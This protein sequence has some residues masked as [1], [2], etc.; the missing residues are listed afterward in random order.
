MKIL[1]VLD[2][3]YPN[4]DGPIEVVVNL[5]KKFIERGNEAELLVPKYP[6]KIE[7]EGLKI[8]RCVSVPAQGY[9]GA[10]PALDGKIKKLIKKGNFDLINLHSPFTLGRCAQKL[11][12]KYGI[13]VVFTMHTKFR[14]EFETR[15]KS[16]FLCK[17]MLNY[18]MKCID[19]CDAVTT[20]SRGTVD[21]LRDYGYK[22]AADVKVIYNGTAMPQR[23]YNAEAVQKL[24]AAL[25]LE[26]KLA[27]TFVGR[28][29]EVK[30]VQFSLAV[31]NKVKKSGLDGF[32]FVIVGDGAYGKTLEKLTADYNLQDNVTFV[33]KISDK[34]LLANYYA[35][36]D[37]LLFPSVFDNASIVI[38]EA[39][40]NGLPVATLQGC[41]SA[42][43][44]TDGVSGFVWK[45]DEDVWAEKI[46]EIIKNPALAAAA[47]EGAVKSV[48]SGWD[49]IAEQYLAY[50]AKA[51]QSLEKS[52]KNG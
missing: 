22:K 20:V 16:K 38:L 25:G 6:Q 40:A 9:R 10:L 48:Y 5:A 12:K 18:V 39:A 23:G 19:A 13:P 7:V 32:K 4:V 44:L 52:G 26:G 27:L 3:F 30:N 31:L 45:N 33:G 15:L 47:G 46:S 11:G 29:A 41:C 34:K 8:H 21:T 2:S 50:Y 43:R 35:A 51:A 49:E 36:C 14:D 42:E 28:L 24:R 1:L 17:F 37:L